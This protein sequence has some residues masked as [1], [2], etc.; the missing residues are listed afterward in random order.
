MKMQPGGRSPQLICVIACDQTV[1]RS[2]PD[3]STSEKTPQTSITPN[4]VVVLCAIVPSSRLLPFL[5]RTSVQS[6][7]RTQ[8]AARLGAIVKRP[9]K[10]QIN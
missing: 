2:M 9:H 8:S 10:N 1:G 6:T 7:T 5:S 4:T 3:R